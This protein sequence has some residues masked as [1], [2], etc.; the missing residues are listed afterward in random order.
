MA[1]INP[2][3]PLATPAP[4]TPIFSHFRLSALVVLIQGLWKWKGLEVIFGWENAMHISAILCLLLSSDASAV[5]IF[6]WDGKKYAVSFL[7]FPRNISP[8]WPVSPWRRKR[9]LS[10][11]C[12][13]CRF[14]RSLWCVMLL[15]KPPSFCKQPLVCLTR[16]RRTG[17]ATLIPDSE[18]NCNWWSVIVGRRSA[19]AGNSSLHFPEP[20]KHTHKRPTRRPRRTLVPEGCVP[21]SQR[22]RSCMRNIR[23][24]ALVL[25]IILK[26]ML[27]FFDLEIRERTELEWRGIHEINIWAKW[28]G[29]VGFV[30]RSF[31]LKDFI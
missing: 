1:L 28:C 6:N 12:H 26:R 31:R 24:I 2:H 15:N 25:C 3:I 19:S 11:S 27:Q 21:E 30:V 18:A 8:A 16:L 9:T 23:N 13:L 5:I 7:S 10:A 22:S 29:C 20:P 14:P 17:Y 4:P